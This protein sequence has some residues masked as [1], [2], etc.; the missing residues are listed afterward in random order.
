[1]D[2]VVNEAASVES[3]PSLDT[4]PVLYMELIVYATA[5]CRM[6]YI[7]DA[8]AWL[9]WSSEDPWAKEL[10]AHDVCRIFLTEVLPHLDTFQVPERMRN[11]CKLLDLHPLFRRVAEGYQY[12][13][14]GGGLPT[15]FVLEPNR[16]FRL[17]SGLSMVNIDVIR[18]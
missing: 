18:P 6:F 5:S 8:S 7:Q 4:L 2:K 1:M 3:T 15:R 11:R 10:S 13:A 9:E 16:D 14:N 12:T 17:I